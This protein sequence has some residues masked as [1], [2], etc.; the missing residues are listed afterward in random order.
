MKAPPL[1]TEALSAE[2]SKER[3]DS[4]AAVYIKGDPRDE[5]ERARLLADAFDEF[6]LKTALEQRRFLRKFGLQETEID[7]I[8]KNPSA[9][10]WRIKGE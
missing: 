8:L 9:L 1:R 4:M 3:E 2:A 6:M 10:Q 7:G 5:E